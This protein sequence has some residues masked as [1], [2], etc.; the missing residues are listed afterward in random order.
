MA[1]NP[2]QQQAVET[3]EGP[4]LVLAG[5][6]SGK[7]RVIVHRIAHLLSMGDP[8]ESIL[9]VTFTNKAAAE[10]KKR[11]ARMAG[12]RAGE[13]LTVSTFH[14]FGVR[15]IQEN[16]SLLELGRRFAIFDTQDQIAL[17]KRILSRTKMAGRS[18]DVKRL[19]SMIS[20]AK[21][22]GLD[23]AAFIVRAREDDPYDVM[24]CELYPQYQ[25]ALRAMGA[26]DFDDLI[27]LPLRLL[28]EHESVRDD[29]RKRYRHIMVDEYQDTSR[30]QVRFLEALV[31]PCGNLCAVGDDDQSIYAWRGAEVDNIFR[32]ER[33]FKGAREVRLTRNYRS[34]QS[35]LDSANA[36]IAHN[37]ARRGKDLWTDEGAGEPVRVV[38]CPDEN[39]EATWTAEKIERLREA[40]RG[41][42]YDDFAILFR[43]NG[44]ARPFEEAL[45]YRGIEHRIVGGTR[46]FDR[47]EVRDGLAYLRACAH[48]RDD[49]SLARIVN[50][51]ARGIGDTT[52]ERVQAASRS[53]GRSLYDTL[54]GIERIP[55]CER[56]S[57]AVLNMIDLMERYRSAF[58]AGNSLAST[59]RSLFTE[60]GLFEAARRS[61]KST[62]AGAAKA[63][64]LEA[65]VTSLATFE[66]RAPSPSL[67]QYLARVS[68]EGRQEEDDPEDRGKLTLLTL[69]AAKGLEFPV[70][71]L[72][73]MEEGLLPHS[74]MHGEVP[75]LPEERRLAY[76]GITR[77][78]S[79]LYLTRAL[80][81]RRHGRKTETIP[82]RFLEDLPGHCV[83]E[84]DVSNTD[85]DV[86]PAELESGPNFFAE[87]RARLSG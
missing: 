63:A 26:V 15:V 37:P 54:R 86:E 64:N 59:A 67:N 22:D 3:V 18:F 51:P 47:K 30:V 71:F 66:S 14:S 34:T 53:R 46:F 87:M 28:Q 55:G 7:T 33:S 72:A 82:S 24:L 50:Y 23:P 40:E 1:L 2:E 58:A 76:V 84:V 35:I 44:Q 62:T 9:A 20:R 43:T 49:V 70:V 6:G 16:S 19:L 4:L 5:A 61:V 80:V 52:L 36:V 74:G 73:G 48:P 31:G 57:Q 32:F 11:V 25:R 81:R 45:R 8:A 69:H 29:Y 41:L 12:R 68:L 65:L 39:E 27:L 85:T 38:I 78:R 56:A 77:A 79:R 10:M 17:L 83:Q 42:S 75:N 21:C 60:V 13:E